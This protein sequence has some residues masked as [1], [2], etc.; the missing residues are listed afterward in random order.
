LLAPRAVSAEE[1]LD[2]P[3][4]SPISLKEPSTLNEFSVSLGMA[5]MMAEKLLA[6]MDAAATGAQAHPSARSWRLLKVHEVD[7]RSPMRM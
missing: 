3:S 1:F 6:F 2:E 5:H 7:L 4:S